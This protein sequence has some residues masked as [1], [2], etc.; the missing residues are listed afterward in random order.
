MASLKSVA[1]RPLLQIPMAITLTLLTIITLTVN[2]SFFCANNR[3]LK[4]VECRFPGLAISN[5]KILIY[6]SKKI[7]GSDFIKQ[8]S[9][10]AMA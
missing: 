8:H 9:E 2:L 10:T 1:L 7:Y 5:A 3:E 6:F 4:C